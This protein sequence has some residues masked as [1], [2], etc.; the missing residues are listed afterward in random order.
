MYPEW[1]GELAIGMAQTAKRS[2]TPRQR[3]FSAGD[4]CIPKRLQARKG[5]MSFLIRLLVNAAALCRHAH[6]A[7]RDLFG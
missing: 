3:R 6:R 4:Q 1:F 5:A 7:G 2:I